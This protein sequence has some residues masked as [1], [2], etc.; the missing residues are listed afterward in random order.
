MRRFDPEL[1]LRLIQQHQVN[2]TF[3][4]PTLLKRIVS[5]PENVQRAPRRLEHAL[6]RGRGRALP[7][8]GQAHG[9]RRCSGRCSTSST[10]PP[11]PG[12]HAHEARDQLR[13]PGSCG[14]PVDG[15]DMRDPRRPGQRVPGECPGEIWVKTERSSPSTAK[16]ERH[17]RRAQGRLLLGGRHRLPRRGRLHLHRRSQAGHGHLGRGQHLLDRDR[18]R[19]PCPSRGLGRRRDRHPRRGVGRVGARHRAAAAGD[20]PRRRRTLGL[21]A[22]APGRLQEASLDRDPPEPAARRGRQ[23]PQARATRAVLAGHEKRV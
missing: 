1:A 20:R 18:E 17:L 7:V 21:R 10:A 22:R 13:K 11:R 19:D 2:N 5:L 14:K 3:M 16:P 15:V 9:A 12:E 23:D 4:A 6:D 8:R